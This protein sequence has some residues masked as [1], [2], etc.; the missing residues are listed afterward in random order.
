MSLAVLIIGHAHSYYRDHDRI[1]PL[2]DIELFKKTC[3]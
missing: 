1:I 2:L 3:P